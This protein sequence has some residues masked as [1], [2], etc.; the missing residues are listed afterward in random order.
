MLFGSRARED[1]REESGYDI[2]VVV[3]DK[4]DWKTKVK[5]YGRVHYRLVR[6]LN[7]PVD[8][9]VFPNKWFWEN[10]RV[11]V[12]FEADVIETG[13]EIPV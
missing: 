12:T 3:K 2:L 8:L 13:I 7:R 5:F 11:K 1:Y 4:L 6:L 9:L 10:A